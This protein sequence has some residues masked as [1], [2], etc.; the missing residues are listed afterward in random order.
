MSS[1]SKDYYAIALKFTAKQIDLLRKERGSAI[2][3]IMHVNVD[4]WIFVNASHSV[5]LKKHLN[6]NKIKTKTLFG[7]LQT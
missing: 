5:F 6:T 2:Y 1:H 3:K 7:K 4:C